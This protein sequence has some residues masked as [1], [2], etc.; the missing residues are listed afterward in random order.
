MEQIAKNYETNSEDLILTDKYYS[1]SQFLV[2]LKSLIKANHD[3]NA[4]FEINN[5]I[6]AH[7]SF[8]NFLVD[9]GYKNVINK[10]IKIF[11]KDQVVCSSDSIEAFGKMIEL[12]VETDIAKISDSSHKPE[13]KKVI[14]D[15]KQRALL[16]IKQYLDASL[17]TKKSLD[18]Q[19]FK[20][21]L[22]ESIQ[23]CASDSKMINATKLLNFI[24][25]YLK[26]NQNSPEKISTF[27]QVK[28]YLEKI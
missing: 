23:K 3:N 11:P 27:V 22:I 21:E 28:E 6:L 8:R 14:I 7:D 18:Y 9:N 5:A 19:L 16:A 4:V 12:L 15:V 24:V 26:Y 2:F 17:K 25:N 13:H 10:V 20:E 1:Y